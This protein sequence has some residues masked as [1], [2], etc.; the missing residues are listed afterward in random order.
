[1]YDNRIWLSDILWPVESELQRNM[2]IIEYIM[3]EYIMDEHKQTPPKQE[4]PGSGILIEMGTE[5]TR[6]ESQWHI[7]S[8]SNI[9]ER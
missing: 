5:R 1:M 4:S 2:N 7:T 6:S 8:S 9:V 3:D